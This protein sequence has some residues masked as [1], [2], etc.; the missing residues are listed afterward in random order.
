LV[1]ILT[2]LTNIVRQRDKIL[3]PQSIDETCSF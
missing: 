1:E 2:H 3:A